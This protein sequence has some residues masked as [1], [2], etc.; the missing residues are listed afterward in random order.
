[1]KATVAVLSVIT[2][3][4]TTISA[5]QEKPAPQSG[6]R[7]PGL[8]AA[9]ETSKGTIVVKLFE[10]EAPLTVAN[11]VELASGKK[12]WKESN[13]RTVTGK[14]FY[15]GVIFH[16]VIANFMVQS[17]AHLADGSYRLS[18]NIP[19]EI[20][21]RLKFDRAGRVAMANTGK[22]NSGNTQFFI[23]HGPVPQLN[24]GYT[25]FGQVVEGQEVVNNM[26][27]VKLLQNE[28][29]EVA[30]PAAAIILNKVSIERV[31][32]PAAEKEKKE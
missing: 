16:R 29:G 3:I 24:G 21:P 15:D 27:K 5:A 4:S 18:T 1:M 22:P 23:T 20:H 19:D 26:P 6:A 17:G 14:P 32:E 10:K 11:F 12:P 9:L 25:I 30:R 8:Y 28:M 7:E 2:L 31:G 13:G